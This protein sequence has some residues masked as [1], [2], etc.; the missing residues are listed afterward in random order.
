MGAGIDTDILGLKLP[1]VAI[2]FGRHDVVR[3]E[4]QHLLAHTSD[5]RRI[6]VI[7]F[8]GPSAGSP[9]FS[10]NKVADKGGRV[11]LLFRRRVEPIVL[12]E[13][14]QGVSVR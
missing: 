5:K 14:E 7:V 11:V 2:F 6:V 10:G 13:R 12:T 8:A 4:A 3:V 9:A 1:L